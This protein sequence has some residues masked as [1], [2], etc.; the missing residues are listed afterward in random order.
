MRWGEL[1]CEYLYDA[2]VIDAVVEEAVPVGAVLG[3]EG[4]QHR[5]TLSPM[6]GRDQHEPPYMYKVF[7]PS[8][9]L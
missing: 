4:L 9:L 3:R 6:K 1:G 2:R 5:R 7:V 8:M